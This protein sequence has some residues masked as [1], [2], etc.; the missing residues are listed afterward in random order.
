MKIYEVMIPTWT[1]LLQ[2]NIS[3]EAPMA[4][5]QHRTTIFNDQSDRGQHILCPISLRR[6]FSNHQ[7]LS[8]IYLRALRKL[9]KFV[10]AELPQQ[11][12]E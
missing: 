3:A 10:D 6:L 12:I 1:D 7:D 8:M 2:L 11:Q 5:A 9:R 4:A